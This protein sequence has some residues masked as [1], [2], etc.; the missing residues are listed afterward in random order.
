LF[1]ETLDGRHEALEFDFAMLLPPF[2]GADLKAYDRSGNDITAELFAPNGFLR[3]DA[4]YAQR[5][6]EE[7]RAEDWPKT[8][9]SPKYANVFG[10]GIAFAPPHPIS[11]P[12]VSP[13]GTVISP[14]PPRTGMPSG[15]MGR[16][17]AHSIADMIS[18]KSTVPTHPASM[19]RMGAACI[20]SAGAGLRDGSAAAMTMYPVVPDYV[21]YP[22]SGRSLKDTYGEVGLAAHWVK[23]LLHFLFIYKAKARPGWA[24]LPE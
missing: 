5:P 11:Q 23:H 15:I 4:D 20:A 10:I 6:F 17:V 9:Q 3:V 1:Y 13:A 12:R 7:W 16:E 2:R 21:R 8:Y 14:A 24:L 22:G 18:G 19:A